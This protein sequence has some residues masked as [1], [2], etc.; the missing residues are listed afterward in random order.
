MSDAA[1]F[2]M[3]L[4]RCNFSDEVQT[5][6]QLECSGTTAGAATAFG[7]CL[8]RDDFTTSAA[9]Y[10]GG[11]VATLRGE[12]PG[13]ILTAV[14]E[15]ALHVL[16]TLVNLANKEE[17]ARLVRAALPPA[18]APAPAE[19][20]DSDASQARVA[21][22]L[23]K[24]YESR[25][26]AH[27]VPAQTRRLA[28]ASVAKM[29]DE[30]TRTG[31]IKTIPKLKK[32]LTEVGRR[33]R[34]D[35]RISISESVTLAVTDESEDSK[36]ALAT[37]TVSAWICLLDGMMAALCVRVATEADGGPPGTDGY[38]AD[39]SRWAAL[40][41][42]TTL[43]ERALACGAEVAPRDFPSA[44]DNAALHLVDAFGEALTHPDAVAK[45]V[46]HTRSAWVPLEEWTPRAPRTDEESGRRGKVGAGLGR[47][48]VPLQ[49]G[50]CRR[51]AETGRCALGGKCPWRLSHMAKNKPASASNRPPTR[52]LNYRDDDRRD[53]DRRDRDRDDRRDDRGYDRRPNDRRSR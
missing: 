45:A 8:L 22:R 49:D 26:G 17:C 48:T 41:L 9:D 4:E 50:T 31:A 28:D 30:Y 35:K 13:I 12:Y 11:I 25:D 27:Q 19:D 21:D 36:P 32:V 46:A 2:S 53:D 20:F 39:G 6:L 5:A 33:L 42:K 34:G 52:Q 37:R 29:H 7:G 3:L 44:L 51:W 47:T 14:D 15:G 10:A 43:L 1:A 40:R 16:A 18:D 38:T 23:W 24:A